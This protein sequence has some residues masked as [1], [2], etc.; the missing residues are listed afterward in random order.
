MRLLIFC[1]LWSLSFL[2]S[3]NILGEP[4]KELIYSVC[5]IPIDFPYIA[6]Y[7]YITVS[8][9]DDQ[10]LSLGAYNYKTH[11]FDLFDLECLQPSADYGFKAEGV[12]EI[13]DV[14]CLSMSADRI[15][16]KNILGVKLFDH[17]LNMISSIPLRRIKDSLGME[18]QTSPRG[19]RIGNYNKLN[20]RE[21]SDKLYLP[22]CPVGVNPEGFE[23]SLGI[24]VDLRTRAV[25]F[26]PLTYPLEYSTLVESY[27]SLLFPSFTDMGNQLIY[28]YAYSSK[29]FVYDKQEKSTKVYSPKSRFTP[30]EAV[31]LAKGIGLKNSVA[32]QRNSLRF[33]EVYAVGDYYFRIHIGEREGKD[34][35]QT[36]YLM[37]LD[38][39]FNPIQEYILPTDFTT[40]YT[41]YQGHIYIQ[42]EMDP[43]NP[44]AELS[45]AVVDVLE[46]I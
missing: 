37:I 17:S 31:P 11:A 3:C 40:V 35:P 30:E 20:Y 16:V 33:L 41:V 29:I 45:L 6:N 38:Q 34:T 10:K 15:M 1:F 23:P 42:K 36:S 22:I 39:K 5:A 44:D 32:Y 24:E 25:T 8:S 14:Q 21:G 12:D 2:V 18:Y 7:P 9:G 4:K 26:L 46:N 43:E 13:S 28:N 27:G 19:I